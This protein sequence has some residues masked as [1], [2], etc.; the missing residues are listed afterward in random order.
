MKIQLR[1]WW[2]LKKILKQRYPQLSEDDLYFTFGREPE[3]ILRLQ[4]KTGKSQEE[5]IR[6]I[7]SIQVA[8]LQHA[9]L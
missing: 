1:D 4:Q 3:L 7:K 9:L 8:Y 6:I 5:V 2:V